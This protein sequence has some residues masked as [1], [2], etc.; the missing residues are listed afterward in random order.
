LRA[1][2]PRDRRDFEPDHHA[3]QHREGLNSG[4]TKRYSC[5][6][7][8]CSE[9]H[10]TILDAIAREKQIKAGSRADKLRLIEALNP[11]WRDLYE[12]IAPS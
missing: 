9:L 12:E 7:L 4:F 1:A 10:G 6:L 11:N 2:K 3:W 5:K 8:V